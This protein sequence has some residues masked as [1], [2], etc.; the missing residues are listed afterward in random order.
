M[1]LK[2]LKRLTF[3]MP[4]RDGS[5]TVMPDMQMGK[6]MLRELMESQ[7]QSS[8]MLLDDTVSTVIE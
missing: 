8:N 1:I 3:T 7:K 6:L 2:H 4:M 5:I